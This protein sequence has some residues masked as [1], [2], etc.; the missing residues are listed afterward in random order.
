MSSVPLGRAANQPLSADD[1]HAAER[2]V[3]ARRARQHGLDRLARQ[4]GGG[5]VVRLEPEQLLLAGGVDRR[6][7]APVGRRAEALGQLVVGG[8]GVASGLGRDLRRQQRE[9]DAVLVGRPRPA[10]A[11]QEGGARALLAAEAQR[12]VDQPVDEPFEA[13]G[14]LDHAPPERLRDLVDHARGDE[15]LADARVRPVAPAAEQVVDRHREVVVRVHQP[16]GRRD[17]PVPVGIGVAGDRDVEA[18]AVFDQAAHDVRR[19]AVH[20]DLAVVVERHEAEGRVDLSVYDLQVEPVPLLDRLE[21]GDRRA[22][23]RVDADVH[24]GLADGVDVDH[25]REVVHVGRHVVVRRGL[26]RRGGDLAPEQLVGLRLHALGDVRARGPAARRVVLVAA[27]L[28]R[29]VRGRQHDA[30]GPGVG[31]D[32]VAERGGRRVAAV[33]VHPHVDPVRA[34]DR[35]RAV[36]RGLGERVRVAS[37]E[38]RPGY[39]LGSPVSR[40]RLAD[41]QDVGFG[42]RALE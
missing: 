22:T 12:T 25:V 28:G 39:P 18:V 3:V 4:L 30:I 31:Q 20:P 14:H 16:R 27:V 29:V 41:G 21:V 34:E 11:A 33:G 42:E 26:R 10:V 5:D 40:D 15:R 19:R 38:Q 13:D 37:H 24:T 32:R 23:Q 17:D 35:Q 7:G 36:E 2:R 8:T 9:Q 6:I 1:L